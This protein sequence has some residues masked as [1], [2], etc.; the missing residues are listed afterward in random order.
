MRL[1]PHN[2]VIGYTLALIRSDEGEPTGAAMHLVFLQPAQRP[3]PVGLQALHPLRRD[4]L[5]RR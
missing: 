3:L 4:Q 5:Q 1:K 2:Q